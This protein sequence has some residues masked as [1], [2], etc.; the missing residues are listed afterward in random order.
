MKGKVNV[1]VGTRLVMG[2]RLFYGVETVGEMGTV[3]CRQLDALP[4]PDFPCE[5]VLSVAQMQCVPL[6]S[7]QPQS[8]T[9]TVTDTQ[10]QE[11][12]EIK[13]K[14]TEVEAMPTTEKSAESNDN[15]DAQCVIADAVMVPPKAEAV[16][17]SDVEPEVDTAS[18]LQKE[19]GQEQEQHEEVD[20]S[21]E[22]DVD[23]DVSLKSEEQKPEE[24]EAAAAEVVSEKP[25]SPRIDLSVFAVDADAESR[26]EQIAQLEQR[27][28]LE[29]VKSEPEPTIDV[30]T[31]EAQQE[32][33]TEQER[34][35]QLEHQY[36]PS[37]SS[38]VY[39][40]FITKQA[41]PEPDAVEQAVDVKHVQSDETQMQV[42]H[43]S[44]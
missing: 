41:E 32:K 29:Q 44:G 11:T 20:A 2:P 14:E 16:S 15:S 42:N 39:G 21:V 1:K 38:G 8:V 30:E 34:T 25:V 17:A 3:L 23:V 12:K 37:L 31:T 28:Y 4:S 40:A 6:L 24:P 27:E 13:E 43:V 7:Q 19:Q 10:T 33:S 18:T 9:D 36:S 5:V 26:S 22:V 35:S